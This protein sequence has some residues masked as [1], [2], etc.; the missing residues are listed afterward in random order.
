MSYSALSGSTVVQT[1]DSGFLV[2]GSAAIY[3]NNEA[4]AILKVDTQGNQVWLKNTA[5]FGNNLLLAKAT[6]GGFAVATTTSRR[7]NGTDRTYDIAEF[8]LTKFD[9]N[10]N[11]LWNRTYDNG[12]MSTSLA[13]F[14]ATAD[15]GFV[16]GGYANIY[17]PSSYS[18]SRSDIVVLRTDSNGNTLWNR[19]YGGREDDVI[20]TI[21]QTSDGGFAITA[22]SFSFKESQGIW[23]IK[24]DPDGAIQWNIIY[25]YFDLGLS[26]SAI[27]PNGGFPTSDKGYLLFGSSSSYQ[28][29]SYQST[30]LVFKTDSNGNVQWT[31][32]P[33]S[34]VKSAVQTQDGGYVLLVDSPGGTTTLIRTDGLGATQWNTTY[35]AFTENFGS[36]LIQSKDS[37]LV[38]T[39]KSANKLWLL[40]TDP[41][42]ASPPVQLP[43]L[44][45]FNNGNASLVW[46]RFSDGLGG[47]SVVQTSDGGFALVGEA[48]II[49][50]SN[51]GPQ[52]VNYSSVIIKID[53]S[54]NE[55]FSKDLPIGDMFIQDNSYFQATIRSVDVILS[56]I[57]Q[58]GDGG[59]ALAGT[60]TLHRNSGSYSNY[61]MAKTDSQGNL[62]WVEQYDFRDELSAF[63]PAADG[64]YILAGSAG[65]FPSVVTHIV[66]T[67]GT[68]KVQ[69]NKDIPVR[70]ATQIIATTDGGYTVLGSTYASSS[71]GSFSGSSII[72]HL[73]SN[74]DV[75]WTNSL[76][77]FSPSTGL[78]TSD[79]GYIVAGLSN[80]RTYLSSSVLLKLDHFG[81][82]SWFKQYDSQTFYYPKSLITCREGGFMFA[83]TTPDHRCIV[84]IDES[85]V[86]EK[87]VTLDTMWTSYSDDTLRVIQASDADYIITGKYIGLNTTEYD[88]TWLAKLSLQ[89]SGPSPSPSIPEFPKAITLLLTLIASILLFSFKKRRHWSPQRNSQVV[90]KKQR[91][92]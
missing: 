26:S 92:T 9:Q 53:G 61:C 48:G 45:P 24:T 64:G 59:Y 67:D 84:K 60:T 22:Y 55:I 69:W 74:G 16:L 1:D 57:V 44:K 10:G 66:K 54:G 13:T 28:S 11:R 86:V 65:S 43:T 91:A 63:A 14:A 23:L 41:V 81:N 88:R 73:N 31:Q 12:A 32:T 15:G 36:P 6:E 56:F 39:G 3:S 42:P 33:T 62:L 35:P 8:S 78:Q 76:T 52:Y 77:G 80:P 58:T 20:K 83:A 70:T 89:T 17:D 30:G 5:A 21:V 90:L 7:V 50:N 87:V 49:Q 72:M 47:Y 19:T 85:G 40:K 4:G 82:M 18:S 2:V 71:G 29:S 68:G 38:I 25:S 75:T 27:Y 46:Q 51:L 79:G 37:G 34:P